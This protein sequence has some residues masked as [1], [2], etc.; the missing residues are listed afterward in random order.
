MFSGF[1]QGGSCYFSVLDT[2]GNDMFSGFTFMFPGFIYM[3][4]GF[5]Q[6][7][8][9]CFLGLHTLNKTTHTAWIRVTNKLQRELGIVYVSAGSSISS[10]VLERRLTVIVFMSESP[11]ILSGCLRQQ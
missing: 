5:V 2:L 10:L 4:P 3:F 1:V 7:G 9:C 8:S 6:G 11:Q